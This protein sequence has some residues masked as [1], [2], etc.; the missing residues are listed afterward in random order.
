M[1]GN[2]LLFSMEK[3]RTYLVC[4]LIH[5]YMHGRNL[6]TEDKVR[7]RNC[8]ANVPQRLNKQERRIPSH[9]HDFHFRCR[10]ERTQP[11]TTAEPSKAILRVSPP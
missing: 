6:T 5:V 10:A 3:W 2:V 9:G 1:F 11:P 8:D 7:T 4:N